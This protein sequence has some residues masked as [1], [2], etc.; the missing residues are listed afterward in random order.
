M[1]KKERIEKKKKEKKEKIITIKT[2]PM[3]KTSMETTL[4]RI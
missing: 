4:N 1:Q 2:F 3:A